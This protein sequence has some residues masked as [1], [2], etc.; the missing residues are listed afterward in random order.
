MLA[1]PNSF[2][3]RWIPWE[4]GLADGFRGIP[5]NAVFPITP[6]GEVSA[7]VKSE[8][9]NLYP[10]PVSMDGARQ[11]IDPRGSNAWPLLDWL[12]TPIR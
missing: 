10:K 7:W 6:E 12:H 2:S 5:S 3:S 11:V 8:Y 4:L 9:S 1:T